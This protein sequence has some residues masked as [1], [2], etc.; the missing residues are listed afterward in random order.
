MEP[1]E[2]CQLIALLDDWEP[3]EK[4]EYDRR[5]SKIL[6]RALSVTEKSIKNWR[7]LEPISRMPRK[8]KNLLASIASVIQAERSLTQ[9]LRLIQID[10]Q[11]LQELYS[12]PR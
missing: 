6:A 3:M 2:F 9:A 8:Q 5:C 4:I 12:K 7:C 1:T 10:R 11:S